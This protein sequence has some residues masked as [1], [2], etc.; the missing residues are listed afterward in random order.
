MSEVD[1]NHTS[2]CKRIRLVQPLLGY[3]HYGRYISEVCIHI[4]VQLCIMLALCLLVTVIIV[5]KRLLSLF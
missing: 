5:M 3:F 1:W 2:L 4:L